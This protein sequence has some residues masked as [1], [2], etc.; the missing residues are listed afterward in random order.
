MGQPSNSGS[1]AILNALALLVF[2]LMTCSGQA[3]ETYDLL[4]KQ[5]TLDNIPRTSSLEYKRSVS[6]PGDLALEKANTGT[7]LLSFTNTD[8]AEL[9]FDSEGVSRRVG[10]FPAS[11]GNPMIMYFLETTVRDLAGMAGGSPYY[12]RNRIKAA[13]LKK[14]PA[15]DL[16]VTLG[17]K[18][19]NSQ[20]IVLY[21]FKDDP[22]SERMRGVETLA[23]TITFSEKVPGWYYSLK[24]ETTTERG[25]RSDLPDT[26]PAYSSAIVFQSERNAR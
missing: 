20:S 19:V 13:L 24:A 14:H 15:R 1:S 3:A 10:T 18:Q 11:V 25:D 2:A 22:A 12:I 6:A 23:L 8:M 9:H 26:L 21:P 4:F 7:I 5:G 16:D 17:G